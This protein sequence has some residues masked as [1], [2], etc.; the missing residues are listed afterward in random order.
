MGG[1][2]DFGVLFNVICVVESGCDPAAVGDG[3]R[4]VGIAQ[5]WTIL[6]DDCNRIL[7]D[8]PWTRGARWPRLFVASDRWLIGPSYEMFELYLTFYRWH[9]GR[10]VSTPRVE[11]LAR[12]WN[13]G[14]DALE[15][16]VAV[17]YGRRVGEMYRAEME[18]LGR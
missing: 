9:I 12:I 15:R 14:P 7:R 4:A 3:G 5:I 18:R 13:G 1:S 8:F 17:E 6:V 16:G 2:V 10:T 11:D